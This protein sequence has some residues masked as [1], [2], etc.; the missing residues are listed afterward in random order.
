MIPRRVAKLISVCQATLEICFQCA[1]LAILRIFVRRRRSKGEPVVRSLWAGTPILTL[2]VKARAERLLGVQADTL[3]Y[4]TFFITHDFT[5]NL[6]PV[7]RA[8]RWSGPLRGSIRRLIKY[9]V[10]AWA[11][12][13][14]DRFHFFFDRGLLPTYG[15][16][17]NDFELK[18]LHELNK[19]IYFY[20]YG[21]DV[22]TRITTESLGKFNC[23]TECPTPG[24]VCICDETIGRQQQAMIAKSA[25][26]VFSM[27]DMIHYTPT[28]RNDLF[29]WPIDLAAE[30]GDRYAPRYPEAMSDRPVRIAHAPNHRGF[31]GT[32]YLIEAVEQLSREGHRIELNLIEKIPNRQALEIYRSADIVFDQCLI[33][34]HGYFAL[35]ALA[36]GKPVIVYIRHPHLYLLAP[37]EC[38][39]IN[40]R[41]DQL[42]VTLRELVLDR[43]RLRSLGI[44]GREYI[45][46]YFSLR[47][48]ANRLERVY[49]ELREDFDRAGPI[50]RPAATRDAA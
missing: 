49:R 34:F 47:A 39:F 25:T 5:F 13:R 21:A 43:P 50:P 19:E 28:S 12:I 27:G 30:G 38:P 35:E 48:F 32:H 16:H 36:L 37:V 9:G 44:R 17:F 41:S 20:A 14:Y 15:F 8:I 42:L 6:A 29:Y 7:M 22:R 40:A 4:D 2:P 33:G 3:V 10:F 45:E 18:V 23:C 46:K 1:F 24:M 26:A 31:K 11:C